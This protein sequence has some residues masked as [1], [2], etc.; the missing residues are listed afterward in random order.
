MKFLT[1]PLMVQQNYLYS[2]AL[3]DCITD[4]ILGEQI[5]IVEKNRLAGIHK[6]YLITPDSVQLVDLKDYS[7]MPGFT[8][9]YV[10][11][12]VL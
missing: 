10:H 2:Y 7:L 1:F 9:L 5:R 4:E 8:D 3:L 6:G 12:R 11:I